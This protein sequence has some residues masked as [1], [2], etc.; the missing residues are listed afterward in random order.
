MGRMI[1]IRFP[2]YEMKQLAPGRRAGRFSFKSR[3]SG[4]ML[5]PESSLPFLAAQGIALTVGGPATCELNAPALRGSP[6][7]TIQ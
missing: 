2:N 4:E 6:A 5:V 3:V 7:S 1:L